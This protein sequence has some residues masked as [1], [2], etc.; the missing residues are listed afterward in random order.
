MFC[1]QCGKEIGDERICPSCGYDNIPIPAV[2]DPEADPGK[3]EALSSLICGICSVA[4]L[5]NIV[6]GILA[7]IFSVN[8]RKTGDGSNEGKVKAGKIC[9]IVGLSLGVASKVL[10]I[11]FSKVIFQFLL[12]LITRP[13]Y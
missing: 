12:D 3:G 11:I 10:G 1:R 7:I 9:G 5:F 4:G 13:V 2:K 6:T 8:Y